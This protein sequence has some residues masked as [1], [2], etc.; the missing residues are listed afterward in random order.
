[1]VKSN[2]NSNKNRYIHSKLSPQPRD[3]TL[4]RLIISKSKTT[5]NNG[6]KGLTTKSSER[7]IISKPPLK[8]GL[9]NQNAIKKKY[10]GLNSA[11]SIFI[12]NNTL[13]NYKNN[14]NNMNNT[15]N[16][17]NC[18]YN[19]IYHNCV[20]ERGN[21]KNIISPYNKLSYIYQKKF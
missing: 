10:I 14:T 12:N 5:K 21:T 11:K 3:N 17:N 4:K 6:I 13:I 8:G 7:I 16:F 2:S 15:Y 18:S 20:T 1:M 9:I 19:G